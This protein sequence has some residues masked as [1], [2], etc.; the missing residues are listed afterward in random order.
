MDLFKNLSE[1][2]GEGC[3]L[4]INIAKTAN[5]MT[6]LV[7]PGNSLVKDAAKNKLAPLT[8][9]GTAE[10]L[11]NGF[12]A[13]IIKP[14][15]STNKM[16]ADIKAFEDAQ[17]AV[18][19]ASEKEKKA[20]ETAKKNT[21]VFAKWMTLAEQNEKEDKLRDARICALKAIGVSDGVAGGKAKAEA[22]I[23]KINEKADGGLFGAVVDKS[24][25]ENITIEN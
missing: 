8:I 11:D 20:K 23:K 4:T 18:K 10:E 24:N 13:A 3:T 12:V 21:D 22:L 9:N 14:V 1:I 5:G 25:G 7:M 6:V 16:F 2:M 15:A 17:A 19:A